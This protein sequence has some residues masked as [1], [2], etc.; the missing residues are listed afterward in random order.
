M[1]KRPTSEVQ[2]SSH[3]LWLGY[4]SPNQ[5]KLTDFT[6]PLWYT[7]NLFNVRKIKSFIKNYKIHNINCF[8]WF[9]TLCINASMTKLTKWIHIYYQMV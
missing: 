2:S 4:G 9:S 6:C 7:R 1:Y 5:T 8:S 3:S